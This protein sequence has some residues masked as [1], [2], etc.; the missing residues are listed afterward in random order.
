AHKILYH[1]S[2]SSNRSPLSPA[3]RSPIL[4]GAA[5]AKMQASG[6]RLEAITAGGGLMRVCVGRAAR[7][8]R[9]LDSR[10]RSR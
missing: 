2:A 10:S 5:G 8:L 7:W 1:G 3:C 4:P 6:E 9:R